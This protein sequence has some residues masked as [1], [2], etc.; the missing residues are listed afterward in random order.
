V[1]IL[2][3]SVSLYSAVLYG[4][5]N[6]TEFDTIQEAFAADGMEAYFKTVRFVVDD[7]LLP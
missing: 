1:S 5:V 6:I 7:N 2:L 4:L 3:L